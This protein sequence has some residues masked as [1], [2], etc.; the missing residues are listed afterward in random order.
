MVALSAET[1]G[2]IAMGRGRLRAGNS[3]EQGLDGNF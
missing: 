1:A 3:A 2:G